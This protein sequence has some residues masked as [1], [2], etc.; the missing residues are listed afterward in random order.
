[1]MCFFR[2]LQIGYLADSGREVGPGLKRHLA[3]CSACR[4]WKRLQDMIGAQLRDGAGIALAKSDLPDRIIA[5]LPRDVQARAPSAGPV[6]FPGLA[7][8]AGIACLFALLALLIVSD[9]PEK[10]VARETDSVS[11]ALQVVTA[12]NP[13][14]LTARVEAPFRN[15]LASLSSDLERGVAF[16]SGCLPRAAIGFEVTSN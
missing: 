7:W 12:A 14:A 2:R 11:R 15:E 5:A 16:V 8:A 3:S 13:A 9:G 4:E 6:L 10:Q 1:M